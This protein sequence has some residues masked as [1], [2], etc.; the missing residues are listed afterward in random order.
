MCI[1]AFLYVNN[2][3]PNFYHY[4]KVLITYIYGYSSRT[5]IFFIILYR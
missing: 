5:N 1:F 4:N 3:I 2:N